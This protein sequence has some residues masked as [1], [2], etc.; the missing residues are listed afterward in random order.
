MNAALAKFRKDFIG[1]LLVSEP[2]EEWIPTSL[3]LAA[4]SAP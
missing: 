4:S 2:G 3:P 1:F